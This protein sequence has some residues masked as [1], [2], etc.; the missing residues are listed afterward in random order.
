MKKTYEIEDFN[1][2]IGK[3][4]KGKTNKIS[5]VQGIKVGHYT[6]DTDENKTGVSVVIPKR[7]NMFTEKFIAASHVINGFGKT[8][9]LVQLNELGT[10]IGHGSGE[11]VIGFSTANII[12]EKENSEIIN[13]KTINENS[14]EKIF[15]AVVEVVEESVLKSMLN[16]ERVE[17]YRDN[18]KESLR[19]FL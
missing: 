10:Y 14:I 16:A 18:V 17:G 3:L 19:D 8:T 7:S 9:G 15:R 2:K 13:L 6:I 12:K 1:I 11:V 5:D 4:P